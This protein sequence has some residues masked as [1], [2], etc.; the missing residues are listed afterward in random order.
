MSSNSIELSWNYYGT[1]F[2]LY[3]TNIVCVKRRINWL[4]SDMLPILFFP[5]RVIFLCYVFK[6]KVVSNPVQTINKSEIVYY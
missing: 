1:I 3:L 6:A 4:C 2:T 5:V